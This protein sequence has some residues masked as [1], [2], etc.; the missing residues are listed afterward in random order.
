MS[1]RATNTTVFFLYLML[2]ASGLGAFLVGTA[3]GRG[4]VVLHGMAGLAL[5]VL[6]FWKGGVV[7]RSLRRHGLGWWALPSLMLLALL[8]A[9]LAIGVLQAT[10][11]LPGVAGYPAMTVHVLLALAMVPFFLVHVRAGWPRPRLS[12]LTSRRLLLQRGVLMAAGAAVWAGTEA[13]SRVAG[14]SGGRRRFT[15]SRAVASAEPNGFPSTS[16][17]FDS[18]SRFD[19]SAWQVTIGG[20][21]RSP[22]I[23]AL[24]SERTLTDARAIL[25][26][27]GAWYVDRTWSGVS[28]SD[29][30][31][32]AGLMSSARS[33][34]VRSAT[35]Y[36]RRFSVAEA[37]RALLAV[38]VDG[39]PLT[40]GHGAPVRLVVPG[41]RGYEW[42]KWVVAVEAST[43]P[44]QLR[45]P[46]PRS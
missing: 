22:L 1:A 14:L 37:G 3:G 35:G 41:K 39:E 24:S 33:I 23:L 42:V 13:G 9:T 26:C 43:W 45:L 28:L 8:L 30:L 12:D 38:T 21:V 11:G 27:T 4:V 40:H 10:V 34:V 16:W 5:T 31:S 29:L 17:L 36:A 44:A 46:L 7:V 18:P 19:A 6:L 32:R 20:T 15:G 2:L 25:D